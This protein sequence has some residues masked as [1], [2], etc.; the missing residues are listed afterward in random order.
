MVMDSKN[1]G[2]LAAVF[3]ALTVVMGGLFVY[4]YSSSSSTSGKY[5]GLQ[6]AYASQQSSVVLEDAY[7]HWGDI[8]I[9]NSSL[10]QGQYSSNAT[11]HWIGGPLTG[12]YTGIGSINSTWSKFFGLW[13]AVWYY[14]VTPPSVSVNG[15]S[16]TVSSQNQFILTPF[17]NETQAQYLN[18]SYTLDY[19]NSGSNWTIYSETW[20]IVGSGFISNSEQ[21][22]NSNNILALAFSHWNNIAIENNTTVMSEYAPN[23]TLHWVGGPL[24]GTYTGT[25]AI[26]TTWNRFFTLWSAVWFYSEA[27]PTVSLN[28]KMA[29]VNAQVQFVVQSASNTSQFKYINVT[30]DIQYYNAGF[31]TTI[32]TPEFMIVSETFNITGNGLLS[33]I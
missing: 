31:E 13:S 8:A 1:L 33:K 27:P 16:A 22:V 5:A 21:F 19:Y 9:E 20:H 14:T 7:A 25:S 30:Y 15:K 18:I 26:N 4:E 12:T 24:N 23:A 29:T 6:S 28:G 32:G 3:I 17:S 2:I 10:M 11:L